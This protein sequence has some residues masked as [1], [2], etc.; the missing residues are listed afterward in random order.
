LGLG[1][2]GLGLGRA[3]AWQGLGLAGLGLGRAWAWQGKSKSPLPIGRGLAWLGYKV[4][5]HSTSRYITQP[6]NR[7][8]TQINSRAV[9]LAG[10]RTSRIIV[11]AISTTRK[12]EVKIFAPF[13]IL[14]P[15]FFGSAF[16]F[17]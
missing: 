7:Q 12:I 5:I 9:A 14:Y 6:K 8:P 16:C 1:L 13:D 11:R 15:S 3:W 10:A 17:P 2:A 4:I